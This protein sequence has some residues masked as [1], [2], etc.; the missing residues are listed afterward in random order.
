MKILVTG[1]QGFIGSHLVVALAGQGH[2][3]VCPVRRPPSGAIDTR[4]KFVPAE[5]SRMV[6]AADWDELLIGVDA[7]INAVG[8]FRGTAQDHETLHT[9]VPRALFAAAARRGARVIQ[10]SALGADAHARTV[11][12]RSKRAADDALRNAGRPAFIVQPSLVYG[13]GGAS[14]AWF[15]K[16]AVLPVLVLPDG[17]RQRIQP[18]HIDDVVDGVVALLHAPCERVA[19]LAF[20]GPRPLSLRAYLQSLREQLGMQGRVVV[21]PLASGFA[22][23][24]AGMAAPL[25]GGMVSRD[26]VDMLARGNTGDPRPFA[27]LLGREPRD[28][29]GFIPPATRD[30][31]RSQAVLG[32]FIP[33]LK[34][35]LAAVWIWTAAVS[36]GLYPVADSLAML[37]RVGLPAWLA[38]LALYGAALLDLLF[39]VLTLTWRGLRARWLWLAQMALIGGYTVIITWSLPEQWLHPFGPISKNLPMLAALWLLYLHDGGKPARR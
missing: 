8:I 31:R 12:H 30:A 6:S 38:P 16:L 24:L 21:L 7:V 34:L 15:E 18:V 17:G 9:R 13:P 28:P 33:L 29:A 26:A 22:R 11:F 2:E 23:A 1:G 35:T 19:T 14:A 25:T 3:L 37:Q 10:I 20:C 39:G 27:R 32:Q 36:F 4:A 5:V